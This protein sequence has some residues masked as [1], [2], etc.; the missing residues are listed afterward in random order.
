M[1]ILSI[2][3]LTYN[4]PDELHFTALSI[5][6]CLTSSSVDFNRAEVIFID[7]SCPSV[8]NSNLDFISKQFVD[9]PDRFRYYLLP[10]SG[11]Y[12]AMNYAISV[13]C[14]D[15]LLFM[16]SGDKFSRQF[17]L[18]CF[19]DAY[20][21]F[22]VRISPA[23]FYGRCIVTSVLNTNLLWPNPPKN[24]LPD[25][26][27]FWNKVI[28]P[29]HQSCFFLR[30]WHLDNLYPTDVGLSADRYIIKRALNRSVFRTIS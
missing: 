16:N 5:Y 22:Y 26:R 2:I 6:E 8:A 19:F 25:K 15:Y 12:N 18:S 4:N 1:T 14:G 24:V 3:C 17:D 9:F 28:P 30:S 11:I 10:P 21:T 7:S 29:S 13:S 23:L 20:D 27:I